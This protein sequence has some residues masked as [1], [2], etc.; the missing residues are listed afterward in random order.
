[1]IG[2]HIIKE[3]M[4]VLMKFGEIFNMIKKLQPGDKQGDYKQEIITKIGSVLNMEPITN[5]RVEVCFKCGRET[6][7]DDQ[8]CPN[9]GG[10]CKSG[11]ECKSCHAKAKP[12]DTFCAGC[13]NKL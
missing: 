5:H 13:G 11:L 12:G 8:F 9:C 10:N 4:S 3:G 7:S 6:N 1:M 2:D